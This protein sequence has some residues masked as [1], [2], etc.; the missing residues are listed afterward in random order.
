MREQSVVG[1]YSLPYT[2]R[3]EWIPFVIFGILGALITL[4]LAPLVVRSPAELPV[5]LFI[6]VPIALFLLWLAWHRIVLL[7]DKLCYYAP[8]SRR[9]MRFVDIT[10]VELHPVSRGVAL[11]IYD[12][13]TT[14]PLMISVKPFS[15]RS[16]AIVIDAIAAHAPG[17]ALDEEARQLRGGVLRRL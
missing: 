13:A 9:E 16:I 3:V 6:W 14:N 2:A 1:S 11:R 7:P 15:K 4:P 8:F 5:L 12:R 17:V 10:R